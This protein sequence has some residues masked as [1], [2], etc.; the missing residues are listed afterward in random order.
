MMRWEITVNGVVQGVGFRPFVHRL[1]KRWALDGSVRNSGQGVCIEVQGE[2]AALKS[3]VAQLREEA[4]P[5]AVIENVAIRVQP[6]AKLCDFVILD[7]RREVSD[8]LVS[9]DIAPCADCLRELHDPH[10]RRYRY[11]FINCTNCGPRYTIIQELPYDRPSTTMAPFAMCDPCLREY[12]DVN[13]RRYHAQPNA[14]ANCGPHLY[15]VREGKKTMEQALEKAIADLKQGRIV[16]IQ[17]IGGI[18][19]ACDACQPAIV[20]ELRRRKQRESKPLAV[21]VRNGTIARRFAN[22]SAQELAVMESRARPIVLCRKKTAT[23]FAYLSANQELGLFLPYTP[24]H[25]LLMDVLEAIVLTSGNRSDDPVLIDPSQALEELTGIADAFLLHDRAIENRCDDSLLRVYRGAPYFVRRSRGYAPAPLALPVDATG[26]LA[27][28]AHQKGSFAL[29][30]GTHAFVSPYIGDLEQWRTMAHYRHTLAAY[31]RLFGIQPKRLVCDQHPDYASTQLAHTMALPLLR[32][33]H[34]YAHMASC[35]VQNQLTQPVFGIIWDGSGLGEDG[36]I[37]GGECLIG[38]LAGFRRVGS[39]HPIL[40]AGGQA[41]IH[42]IVRVALA[43][44]TQAGIQRKLMDAD[45]QQR[46]QQL[47]AQPSLCVEASSI[48]RLFDGVYALINGACAQS[49]DGEAAVLLESLGDP[50]EKGSYPLAFYTRAGVRFFD[51]RAM[52]RL[53]VQELDAGIPSSLIAARF[54]NTLC[55]MALE[56]CMVLNPQRLPIVLSGGSFLNVW[57]LEGIRSRLSEKGYDVYWHTQTSCNDEGI[58]LGQL[59]VAAWR[60]R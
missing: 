33:Q 18:H 32:L 23:A 41:A 51:W 52:I 44:C 59:A 50:M 22:V 34:H 31:Q 3:F 1:A 57:L 40:L 2:E 21:M 15:Y 54:M 5:L 36:T 24:L 19:L 9:P 10:D 20:E 48:G 55:A 56:Q 46:L 53:M 4:P 26:I 30:K 8:T 16:A 17:G 29:G 43:L 25:V 47:L 49:Y 7:S 45:W 14:C 12:H 35:M 39:I 28:G 27:L 60:E 6:P 38:D 42:E 11:P 58:A 37:W 13:D